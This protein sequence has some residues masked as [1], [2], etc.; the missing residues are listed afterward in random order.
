[1]HRQSCASNTMVEASTV[2][3]YKAGLCESAGVQMVGGVRA[4]SILPSGKLRLLP[5]LTLPHLPGGSLERRR[6]LVH[7]LVRQR[8]RLP[9]R[10]KQF[11]SGSAAL[12]CLCTLQTTGTLCKAPRMQHRHECPSAVRGQRSKGTGRPQATASRLTSQATARCKGTDRAHPRLERQ[13][14]RR[15]GAS[16]VELGGRAAVA[17]QRPRWAWWQPQP[18]A[19][20]AGMPF[21]RAALAPSACQRLRDAGISLRVVSSMHQIDRHGCRVQRSTRLLSVCFVCSLAQLEAN[22]RVNQS[23]G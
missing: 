11:Y 23:D 21:S 20:C 14:R 7:I 3:C 15:R 9:L 22:E 12:Q 8:H 17:W 2:D 4:A 16:T 19:H 18:L 6:P 13:R 10:K 5:S 1:M